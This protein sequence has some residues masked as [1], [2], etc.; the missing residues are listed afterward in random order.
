MPLGTFRGAGFALSLFVDAHSP[1]LAIYGAG[2]GHEDS[3]IFL[4][5]SNHT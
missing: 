2:G 3:H 1:F 5:Y 4:L